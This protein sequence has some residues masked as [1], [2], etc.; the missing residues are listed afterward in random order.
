[1]K[2]KQKERSEQMERQFKIRG[3]LIPFAWLSR[4]NN[5]YKVKKANHMN[6]SHLNM[7][8]SHHLVSTMVKG[9][10]RKESKL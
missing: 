4:K 1:M 7:I 9:E 10:F 6:V 5:L 3:I 8:T 2:L